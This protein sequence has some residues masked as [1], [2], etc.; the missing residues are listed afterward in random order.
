MSFGFPKRIEA[1]QE[2]IK[3][4]FYRDVIMFA[5]TSNEGGNEKIA[6]PAN[7][8]SMVIGIH[9]TNGQGNKSRFTPNLHPR[10]ENFAT[11]G[12]CIESAW[13]SRL[14]KGDTQY[15]SGTSYATPIA[16]AAAAALL[17]YV[18][19]KLP[20][21]KYINTRKLRSCDGMKAAL[22]VMSVERDR[23]NYIR[24]W[25][26]LNTEEDDYEDIISRR[27]LESLRDI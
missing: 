19:C 15:K 16:V 25:L 6:Y 13:P 1:I 5:A 23:Y 14:G 20:E 17:Q 4:A 22:R 11:L 21:T 18:R 8:H 27:I 7:Q 9:S 26:L 12:E 2:A 10:T 3:H 24:P